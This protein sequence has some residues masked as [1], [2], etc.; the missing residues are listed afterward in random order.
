MKNTDDSEWELLKTNLADLNDNTNNLFKIMDEH[1][2]VSDN[3][4]IR[5]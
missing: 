1:K 4:F 5:L 2:K 3:V